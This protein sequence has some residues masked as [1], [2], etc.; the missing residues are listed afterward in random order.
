MERRHQKVVETA[1]A[2]AL[3]E[4]Q[5]AQ[6]CE[7]AVRLA[8]AAGYQNAGTARFL[9]DAASGRF[10]FIEVNPRPGR[11]H[12][13]E[14]VTG[15]DIVKAQI[16]IAQ[17]AKIG[18]PDSGVPLQDAI[19]LNGCALQCRITTED[20][21]NRFIPDYG[22]ISAYRATGFG[23]RLDGGPPTPA[24]SSRRSTTHCSRR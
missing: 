10:F 18:T 8:Q 17:G 4:D 1:P 23:I 16:R 7:A 21:E 24:P 15:I 11:V 14:V 19:T 2:T 3:T 22:R 20:P 6:L 5:R 9:M 13:T 12:V